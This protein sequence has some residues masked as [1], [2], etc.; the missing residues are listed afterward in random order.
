MQITSSKP[1]I[2][3]YGNTDSG[4]PMF[5]PPAANEGNLPSPGNTIRFGQTEL[6]DTG[7]TGGKG[8]TGEG[9]TGGTGTLIN[10]L[11]SLING[12]LKKKGD[13]ANNNIRIAMPPASGQGNDAAA[14]LATNRVVVPEEDG[15]DGYTPLPQTANRA[16]VPGQSGETPPPLT[17]NRAAVPGQSGDTAPPMAAN[18]STGPGKIDGDVADLTAIRLT[19]QEAPAGVSIG[20]EP[21]LHSEDTDAIDNSKYSSPDELKKYDALV[22]NLPPEERLQA[23][24]EMNRPVAAAKMAAEGGADAD[25]AKAFIDANPALKIATDTG[26]HGDKPDGKTST[27][28]YKA[29]A[30]NMEKAR[31]AATK[32]ISDYQSAH[33]NADPQSLQ[34]VISAATLRANE[35]LI[36]CGA[37]DKDGNVDACITGD[38]LKGILDKNPGLSAVLRQS[39]KTFS[40]P[41]FLNLLDQGGL[42]GKAL[43]LHNPDKKFN[44]GNIDAWIKSQAPTSGGEFSSMISDAATLNAVSDVDISKLNE[45]IFNNP[46]N[47]TGEQKAAVMV[48]LQQ[49][50]GQVEGGSSL[51]HIDKTRQ[52]LLEKI[53][54]LQADPDV[55]SYLN[56]A[57][58]ASEKNM[59]AGDPALSKAVSQRYDDVTSGKALEQDM[60]AARDKADNANKGKKPED[61]E[62]VDYSVAM[63]NIDAEL[64]LQGDLKGAG[65]NVPTLEGLINS[66]SDLKGDIRNS[67]DESFTK[68]K[69]AERGLKDNPKGDAEKILSDVDKKKAIY[70]AAIPDSAT[71]ASEE[72]YAS[73]TMKALSSTKP[74]MG[75]INKLKDTGVLPHDIDPKNMSGK[76]LYTHLREG[77]E[78]KIGPTGMNFA[79]QASH[80]GGGALSV[81]GLASVAEQ[82]KSGD[83][84]G[85]AQSLYD[86]IR[87]SAE[88]GYRGAAKVLSREASSGL[89]RMA[90]SAIGRVVGTVA[91]E[92]A[93]FAAAESLGAAAGPV[94]WVVDAALSIALIVK[95]I[96]DAVH[97]H[98][99]Q[100]TF[101]HNV[102]PTLKQFGIPTPS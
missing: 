67:Y 90:G 102:D 24:K 31:D 63:A 8:E 38:A 45:D 37:Q 28:D 79:K 30:S 19:A 55:K 50:A 88:A 25:R 10:D 60:H 11:T 40:Q 42:E 20:V 46:Q 94:G 95:A 71:A 100:K 59:I 3:S 36:R 84:L 61:A 92:A 7:D 65:A 97:K 49:T 32:D 64:K 66:H 23:E 89:G 91:G 81:I 35:P 1:G 13:P 17:A 52:A 101:D 77:V 4:S 80:I 6:A 33:P 73:S 86:G 2:D 43:A 16:A 22:A 82:L 54:Q 34:M 44:S 39:T 99:D 85:A 69:A 5:N 75:L 51:R 57:V 78:R 96:V 21:T 12:F 14:P 70:E 27:N 53:A 15:E 98:R 47:Y 56:Q 9:A 72:G 93:G 68:G 48:K 62:P 83:K 87:G 74:G 76:E 18:R 26:Q 29:F 58:P 41:G